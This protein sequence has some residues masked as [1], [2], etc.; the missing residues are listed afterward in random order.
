MQPRTSS[1]LAAAPI[2][3]AGSN[4]SGAY[5]GPSPP[6]ESLSIT[7]PD[8]HEAPVVSAHP[9]ATSAALSALPSSNSCH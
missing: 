5:T 1:S 7:H 2:H 3:A 6:P 4:P 8:S 9:V